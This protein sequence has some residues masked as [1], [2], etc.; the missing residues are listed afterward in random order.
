MVEFTRR[1]LMATSVAASLGASVPGVA[2][3][4]HNEGD[5]ENT[6][7]APGVEGELERFATTA[8]GAEVTGPF[9]TPTGTLIF[10]LQHPSRENPAPYNKGGVGYV[11]GHSFG[12]DS[13]DFD[14]LSIPTTEQ[15]R[16]KVRVANGEFELL[17]S[18]GDNIGNNEDY[19]IPV[20]PDGVPVDEFA[21]S[22]YF[23]LG[24]THDM[25]QFVATNDDGTEGLLFTNIETSP[26][27]VVRMPISQ[28]E[29]GTWD[30]DLE[31]TINL[32]NT[33]ALRSIG[34]TR[35]NCYG[36]LSPWNTALS[37]EEEYAH[38]RVSTT[39]TV[40][41]IVEDGT[42]VGHRGGAQFWNR[43]NPSEIQEAI[44]EYYGDDSWDVQGFWALA[45]VE[46]HAYYLGA[47][48]VDQ[49]DGSLENT[50][51]PIGEGYPNPYRTGYIV[52]YREPEA[53][54]P[55]P[56]K[57]YVWGRA[58]WECPDVQ[59]DR[60]TVYLTS[61][62]ANKGLYKFVADEPVPDY[63]DPMEL[64]G[65]LFAAKVTNQDAAAHEPPAEVDLEL[66]WI[67][68]GSA[69]NRDVA[70]W[71]AEYDDV[72][73]E[74]Y[75]DHADTD[76]EEDFERALKEADREVAENG[77]RD[78]I[79]DEEIVEWGRQWEEDGPD[80]VDEELL[81]V[82]FLETRAAAKEVGA[83]VEFRKSEGIDSV[84]GAEPGDYIY[85]GISEV[86]DGM[87]DHEGD[88]QVDRVDGGL[89]YRAEIEEDYD[90]STL[91]PVIVG[92]DGSDPADVA[93]DALLN[94]DNVWV[95]DDGRVLCCEDAAQFGRSYPN[96]CLYVYT[97]G[98]GFDGEGERDDLCPVEA[99]EKGDD[100]D[101]ELDD[102]KGDDEDSEMDDE[103]D[104]ET[105]EEGRADDEDDDQ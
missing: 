34:G 24:Y 46:L 52:D 51:T 69:R 105:G 90:I 14:E 30:S 75:L 48:P 15:E 6:P 10:S 16:G 62:G 81:R 79:A 72:D 11:K 13:D 3:A 38:T 57:Y 60:Q 97:P 67:E 86:N 1:E 68:L 64:E 93:D 37:A 22:R 89:V 71:I 40:S 76:W 18:E 4:D 74:D 32:S 23:D 35:I 83:T 45:G 27:N 56:V 12:G 42:G 85:V 92:P 39:S 41:D 55:R 26:G 95:M 2:G 82:P 78:Y 104:E 20:T 44:N 31:N 84:E 47:D 91:E 5:D 25:N 33:E 49:E 96:D 88:V 17:A 98:E 102:E 28:N 77:N 94:I 21:G 53:D 29:D 80:G 54:P 19:G 87:S 66:E 8:F 101:D 7:L 59:N 63:D 65:T 103:E 73:Q 9:V 70:S 99:D 50:T 100:E 58:A 36:D 43:P 61:D